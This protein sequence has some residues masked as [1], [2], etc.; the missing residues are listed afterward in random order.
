MRRTTLVLI[1]GAIITALAVGAVA[2]TALAHSG[3]DTQ[4]SNP[5]GDASPYA[6]AENT[7]DARAQ[8]IAYWMEERMGPDGVAAFEEQTGTTVEAVAQGMAEHMVPWGGTASERSQYGR[9]GSGPSWFG[10]ADNYG[11]GGYGP[12]A[13]HHGGYGMGG[14]G[15][16]GHSMGGHGSGGY[17]MGGSGWGGW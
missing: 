15:M 17:G 8:S 14:P 1:T 2:P 13:P 6:D 10:P 11:P 4:T 3:T 9:F 12:Q 7:T 16:G 5:Y